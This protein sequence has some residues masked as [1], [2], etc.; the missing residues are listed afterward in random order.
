MSQQAQQ[1]TGRT[2]VTVLADR[3][4][5]SGRQIVACEKA[6]MV[7]YVPKPYTSGAKAEA[8]SANRTSSLCLATTY[9]AVRPETG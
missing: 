9:T 8:G 1:A 5:F 6:G 7:P 4:Y 3:G 2:A